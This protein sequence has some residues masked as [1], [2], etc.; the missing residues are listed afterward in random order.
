MALK[1]TKVVLVRDAQFGVVMRTYGIPP[2][3][4]K[5]RRLADDTM[6]FDM[7][8]AKRAARAR[9]GKSVTLYY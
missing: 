8:K 9:F 6:A 2:R 1:V 5:V 3:C 4:R 7:R